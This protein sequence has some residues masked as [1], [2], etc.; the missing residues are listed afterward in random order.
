[1]VLIK[2]CSHYLAYDEETT[3]ILHRYPVR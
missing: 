3:Q 1:V 2:T